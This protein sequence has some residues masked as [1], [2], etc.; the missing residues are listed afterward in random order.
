VKTCGS[1]INHCAAPAS[2]SG[3]TGDVLALISG[4]CCNSTDRQNVLGNTSIDSDTCELSLSSS[5]VKKYPAGATFNLCA[6]N[7]ADESY[8]VTMERDIT[9]R[10]CDS[11]SSNSNTVIIVVCVVVPCI[12]LF[13]LIGYFVW[14]RWFKKNP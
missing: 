13:S 9:V 5:E 14:R 6:W 10:N 11:S 12:V 7:T 3:E 2:A 1:T 8:C 4:E